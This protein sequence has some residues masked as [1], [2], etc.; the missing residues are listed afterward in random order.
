MPLPIPQQRKP[1][2]VPPF[3]VRAYAPSFLRGNLMKDKNTKKEIEIL[4]CIL[5]SERKLKAEDF[6]KLRVDLSSLQ[7]AV[8]KRVVCRGES[9]SEISSH[10]GLARK[11]IFSL[12]A[13]AIEKIK[14]H[15]RRLTERNC[16]LIWPQFPSDQKRCHR[17]KDKLKGKFKYCPYCIWDELQDS[18]LNFDPNR[19]YTKRKAFCDV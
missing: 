14:R 3:Q 17:C 4:N 6:K 5:N 2:P 10:L 19:L 1:G 18:I 12:Y 16:E 7:R 11:D 15:R 9:I 8:L 13:S